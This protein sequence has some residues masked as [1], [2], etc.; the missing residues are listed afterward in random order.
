LPIEEALASINPV[1][2]DYIKSQAVSATYYDGVG[3]FGEMTHLEPLQGYMLKTSHSETLIFP[4]CET[5]GTF[6]DERDDHEYKMVKIGEQ[7]WMTENLA[8]LPVVSPSSNGSDADLYYYVYG[9]EGTDVS[10]AKATD[11]YTTYG[12]LYN[13]PA[14]LTACPDGWH[15]PTDEEWKTLEKYLGMS[16]SDADDNNWRN[17]GDVGLKLKSTSGWL[18]NG[19]GD[20]SSGFNAF[21]GGLRDYFGGFGYLG[22]RAYFWSSSPDG[23]SDAWH[24]SLSFE[25]G[26]VDRNH[27]E[28]RWGFPVRCLQN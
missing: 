7:T 27:F 16:S 24:R 14:A 2:S 25:S 22:Y 6:V 10:E 5:D 18:E 9:Y 4:G 13:Y 3:W 12:A 23:S 19:D 21:S 1:V 17:S 20:N 11:N 26:G 15:L 28:R 8:W